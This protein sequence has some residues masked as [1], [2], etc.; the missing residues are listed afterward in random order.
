MGIRPAIVLF[1]ALII[2][3]GEAHAK[4]ETLAERGKRMCEQAGVPLSECVALPPV[5]RDGPSGGGSFG[6]VIL[7]E[8]EVVARIEAPP[9]IEAD[10]PPEVYASRKFAGPNEFPPEDYAAYGILAFETDPVE[11]TRDT[12]ERREMICRA[13][14]AAIPHTD[15]VTAAS[16]PINVQMVTV[17]PVK[18]GDHLTD[19]NQLEV[20]PACST[21]VRHYDV[22]TASDAVRHARAAGVE[23]DDGIGPYLLAWSPAR[24]KGE[25]DAVVLR[26][27]LSKIRRPE[28]ARRLMKR[29]R[30]EIER[31][32]ELWLDGWQEERVVIVIR[33]F[34]DDFGEGILSFFGG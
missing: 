4:G 33:D 34:A 27:D 22:I 8:V 32:P 11:G 5:L 17:W 12:R 29:W 24:T 9:A 6:D 1:L 26:L 3:A 16:R 23:F 30:D 19:I 14:V 10:F 7:P 21:A 13:Y 2:P 20:G 28:Q 31:R 25:A 15:E 18:D